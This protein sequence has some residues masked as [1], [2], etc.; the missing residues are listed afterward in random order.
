MRSLNLH[1]FNDHYETT[2]PRNRSGEIYSELR[3]RHHAK[4]AKEGELR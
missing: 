3:P 4:A 1:D 2:D